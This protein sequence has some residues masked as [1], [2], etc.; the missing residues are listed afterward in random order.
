MAK[1]AT[2]P[3]WDSNGTNAVEPDASY[4]SDGWVNGEAVDSSFFNWFMMWVYAWLAFL[5]PF[6]GDNGL[7]EAST[8][9]WQTPVAAGN[10]ATN[11]TEA[12]I[13]GHGVAANANSA[14]V[15][16]ACTIDV[17]PGDRITS[18]KARALGT[19]AA[20]SIVVTLYRHYNN[21]GTETS[22]PLGILTITDP[23]ATTAE[24]TENMADYTV[25]DG[26]VLSWD[27]DIGLDTSAVYAVGL[28]KDRLNG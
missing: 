27:I 26:D 20:Q 2:V 13:S 6:F 16:N 1:P 10:G 15:S 28:T 22:A 23:P 21:A 18:I 11:V 7:I 19:G 4:K 24:Y 14:S 3:E 12:S 8:T 9:R 17:R 25:V 5:D